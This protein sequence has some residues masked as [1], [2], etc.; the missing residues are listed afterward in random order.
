MAVKYAKA[1]INKGFDA[2]MDTAIGIENEYFA[3]CFATEDQKEGMTA[4]LEKRNAEFKG[5]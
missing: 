1:A 3:M 2:D 4:F 5:K